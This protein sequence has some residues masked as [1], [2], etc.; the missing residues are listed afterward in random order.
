MKK[1]IILIV[2]AFSLVLQTQTVFAADD[3]NDFRNAVRD[4]NFSKAERILKNNVRKWSIKDQENCWYYTYAFNI[5]ST[6]QMRAAQLLR[7]YNVS[8]GDN[9]VSLAMAYKNSEELIRFFIDSGMPI[10]AGAVYRGISNEYS[11][12]LV[13]VLLNK[14]AEIDNQDLRKAAEQKRWALVTTLIDKLNEDDM[15]YRQ[16]RD[17][18]T[19]WYNSQSVDYKNKNSFN[20]D[21]IKSKTALMFAAQ[22]GQ[23]KIVK[24]LVEKGAKVNL[25]ADGG[26]TAA[27]LAYD[28]GEI[29]IYNYLKQQGAI[30]YEP[31]Q[32]VQQATPAPSSTTNVYVQPSAP[33]PSSSSS[34]STPSRNV[35]KEIADAFKPPLQSGTYSLV[36]SQEKIS[37]AGIA[38]TGIITQTWQGKTYQGTYNIDGNRMTVQIR[39]F[40]FVFNITSETSFS[41]HNETWV[42]TGF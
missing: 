42:R 35:G 2:M 33:A 4:N 26:E 30:D 41:G 21:P 24:L 12:N 15:S 29:E 14:R 25:R 38:K 8:F 10:G 5:S 39:G 23:F 6:A 27:S 1:K 19:A 13:Q 11:D 22:S 7:Q 36:G 20:Y 3:Y 18:Y 37:I 9:S 40:T 31:K 32:V 17:E 34:S 28:N 16:T